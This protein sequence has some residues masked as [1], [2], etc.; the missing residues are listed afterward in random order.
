MAFR[1]PTTYSCICKKTKN[2]KANLEKLKDA[3]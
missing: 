1:I 2:L 3:C